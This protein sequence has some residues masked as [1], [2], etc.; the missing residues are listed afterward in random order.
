MTK[1]LTE[2][3]RE[4]TLGNG[5]Y[6]VMSGWSTSIEI[7]YLGESFFEG[8]IKVLAPVPDYGS[9]Y[10]PNDGRIPVGLF[11][12]LKLI[13]RDIE[14][15]Q[16]IR[17]LT[18]LECGIKSQVVSLLKRWGW[19]LGK[20]ELVSN[21]DELVQKMHILEKRLEIAAKALSDIE[22]GYSEATG[23]GQTVRQALKEMEGVK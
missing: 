17:H 7:R 18:D 13:K 20:D 14:Q 21:S 2:Q 12:V 6:Y 15:C 1:T 5:F 10:N 4:G 16:K 9:L 19:D 23:A 3:W 11:T 8:N 22:D